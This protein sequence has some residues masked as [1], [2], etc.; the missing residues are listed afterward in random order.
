[1]G[2]SDLSIE[3]LLEVAVG[4]LK[5]EINQEWEEMQTLAPD[6]QI[7]SQQIIEKYNELINECNLRLGIGCK[8][9]GSEEVEEDKDFCIECTRIA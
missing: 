6:L 9:C 1:M 3:Q 5:I 2:L 7:K 4:F 8:N